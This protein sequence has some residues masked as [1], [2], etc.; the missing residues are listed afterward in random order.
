MTQP[1]VFP[2]RGPLT[3]RIVD[4]F[5]SHGKRID[6]A[7]G[8][9]R[10]H[11]G[12]DIMARVGTPIVSTTDGEIV[13]VFRDTPREGHGVAIRDPDGWIHVYAH[14]NAPARAHVGD[15]VHAG[16][17]IG[18]LGA[19]GD[20][21]G[22]HLHYQV[23]RRGRRLNVTRAIQATHAAMEQVNGPSTGD[24]FWERMRFVKHGRER[25]AREAQSRNAAIA[26]ANADTRRAPDG[27]PFPSNPSHGRQRTL[28][29]D[30]DFV[31]AHPA[32]ADSI[33]STD[34]I[35]PVAVGAAV[36]WWIAR[37]K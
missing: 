18:E 21:V 26:T 29:D 8:A 2:V 23:E 31:R 9:P 10:E 16:D 37:K 36:L 11:Q 3:G 19:S 7:T 4:T 30:L 13:R 22:P 34:V 28:S 6:P 14:F 35:V 27:T 24:G 5:H 12:V 17:R 25:R 33:S 20:A 32:H 15:V 1:E